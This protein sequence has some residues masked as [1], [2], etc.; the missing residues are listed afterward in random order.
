MFING[1]GETNCAI[2]SFGSDTNA[3]ARRSLAAEK[4]F[5]FVISSEARNLFVIKSQRKRGS[6][7]RGAPRNDKKFSFFPGSSGSSDASTAARP[8]TRSPASPPTIPLTKR[9]SSRSMHPVSLAHE[10]ASPRRHIRARLQC[11]G[12]TR[13]ANRE[14]RLGDRGG[15]RGGAIQFAIEVAKA[16]AGPSLEHMPRISLGR[17]PFKAPGQESV[18]VRRSPIREISSVES[19]HT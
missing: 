10:R 16:I 6:S 17:D 9:G 7:A 11:V 4:V 2:D 15:C 8:A 14:N 18:L 13:Y 1:V 12:R 3:V 19:H 5:H